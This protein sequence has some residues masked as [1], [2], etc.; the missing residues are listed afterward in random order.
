MGVFI[1]WC[2]AWDL[3]CVVADEDFHQLGKSMQQRLKAAYRPGT[4]ANHSSQF[5][6]YINFCQRY[7]L[8]DVD[9][10]VDTLCLYAEFLARSFK[11]FKSLSNYLGAVSTLHKLLDQP[12][13]AYES[14]RFHLMRRALSLTMYHI[15]DQKA[16]ITPGLLRELCHA[17]DYMG[18][19]GVLFKCLFTLAFFSFLRSSNL[20]SH[21]GKV[22]DRSRQLCRGDIIKQPGCLIVLIKWS[23]TKQVRDNVECIALTALP[24]CDICPVQ[25]F[26]NFTR[27]F[28]VSLN[29]PLFSYVTRARL[30]VLTVSKVQ[31]VLK[32]LLEIS[33]HVSARYTLHSFRRGGCTTAHQCLADP[34]RIKQHGLWSSS[35]FERYITP[36][37]EDKLKVTKL[38][39]QAFD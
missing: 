25:A 2:D 29:A 26:K 6:L 28:P 11:S 39:G 33:G 38:M 21:S 4:T 37:L 5:R 22:F 10:D 24:H 34:L 7:K 35:A 23:K 12:C 3:T 18:P 36:G 19:L 14:F 20:L 8:R 17:T 1:I 15:T 13:Q 31:K 32:S 27:Q 16:A 30:K 9:P